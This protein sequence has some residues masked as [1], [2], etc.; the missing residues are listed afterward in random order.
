MTSTRENIFA[1]VVDDFSKIFSILMHFRGWKY[2]FS[3]SYEQ[4]YISLCLPKLLAPYVSLQ[5]ISWNPL[6][7]SEYMKFE[8]MAWLRD[9]LFY[10]FNDEYKT[11]SDLHLIP[12]VI[13]L[14]V[15]PKLTG[16]Q[17]YHV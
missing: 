3:A 1:D 17:K 8:E 7:S 12:R 6:N 5:L 14:T 9:L 11:D 16:M 13:E 4:A 15:F 10:E 2:N